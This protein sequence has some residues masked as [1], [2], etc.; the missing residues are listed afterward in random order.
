MKRMNLA[1]SKPSGLLGTREPTHTSI[2]SLG[3]NCI[4]I[5]RIKDT[6][7]PYGVRIAEV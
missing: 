1:Y 2:G 7:T 4:I 5:S 3:I 6:S